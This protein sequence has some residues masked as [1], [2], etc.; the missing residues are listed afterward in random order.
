Q[1]GQ[2][3]EK[4]VNSLTPDQANRLMNGEILGYDDL[5]PQ[6]RQDAHTWALGA[7]GWGDNADFALGGLE[8]GVQISRSTGAPF[9]PFEG[10]HAGDLF[11]RF[12]GGYG[13][14]GRLWRSGWGR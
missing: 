14:E 10:P 11:G 9:G 1:M 4:V 3:F 5:T 6:Q 12:E 2:A 13:Q 7:I 8:R